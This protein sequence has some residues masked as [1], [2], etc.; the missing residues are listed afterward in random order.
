MIK[1]Q[2]HNFSFKSQ[3][4]AMKFIRLEMSPPPPPGN[5]QK[6]H[7]FGEKRLS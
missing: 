3:K 1:T 6:F 2:D 7:L 4:I 5:F